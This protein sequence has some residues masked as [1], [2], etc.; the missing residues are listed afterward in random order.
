VR[1][2][3]RV[4]DF[5]AELRLERIETLEEI[6]KEGVGLAHR[7]AYFGIDHVVKTTGRPFPAAEPR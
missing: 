4:G 5:R 1:R 3:D 7:F 6:Q 2:A